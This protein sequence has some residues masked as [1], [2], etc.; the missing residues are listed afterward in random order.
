MSPLFTYKDLCSIE[1]T[2][3]KLNTIAITLSPAGSKD[4]EN[5]AALLYIISNLRASA[6]LWRSDLPATRDTGTEQL[7]ALFK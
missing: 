4:R 3:E 6:D 2:A 1:D 5:T 7:L